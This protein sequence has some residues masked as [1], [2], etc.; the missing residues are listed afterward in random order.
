MKLM[1]R[2]FETF[3][4]HAF[5]LVLVTWLKNGEF[6]ELKRYNIVDDLKSALGCLL[7]DWR[8]S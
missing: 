8:P 5:A 4:S 2:N 6:D 7:S 1:T 3:S